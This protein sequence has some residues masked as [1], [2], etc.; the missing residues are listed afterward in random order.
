MGVTFLSSACALLDDQAVKKTAPASLIATPTS[1]YS[2]AKAKYLAAKYKENLDRIVERIVRNPKTSALQFANNI[3]SVGGIGFFTHSATKTPDERYLEVVLAT[4]ETFES[5]IDVS[6]KVQQLFSSYGTELLG[7]LASDAEIYR[8]QEMSGYGVNLAWRN[9]ASNPAGNRVTLAR[10]IVY[11]PKERVLRFLRKEINQNELLSE[12]VIFAVDEDGPLSLV[13]YRPQTLRAELRPTIREDDL[14]GSPAPAAKAP[15][16]SAVSLQGKEEQQKTE[17]GVEVAKGEGAADHSA[18]QARQQPNKADAKEVFASA[19]KSAAE[20]ARIG[21]EGQASERTTA[22]QRKESPQGASTAEAKKSSAKGAPS[23]QLK[24]EIKSEPIKSAPKAPPSIATA[25]GK[26][27]AS[28][29]NSEN[30]GA[31]IEKV[32]GKASGAEVPQKVA[33]QEKTP[34][35]AAPSAEPAKSAPRIVAAEAPQVP[36]AASHPETRS[37]S[38][39][40][41][42]AV[43]TSPPMEPVVAQK[44]DKKEA[45]PGVKPERAVVAPRQPEAFP[46]SQSDKASPTVEAKAQP[47]SGAIASTKPA[48][49]V[50]EA[51]QSTPSVRPPAKLAVEEKVA[52]APGGEVALMEPATSLKVPAKEEAKALATSSAAKADV[53]NVAAKPAAPPVAAKPQALLPKQS[54]NEA[55]GLNKL[56]ELAAETI[57]A[58]KPTAPAS[59]AEPLKAP[60]VPEPQKTA[61]APKIAPPAEAKTAE[62]AGGAVKRETHAEKSAGE[63]LALLTKPTQPPMEKT[64]ALVP[65]QRALEGFVIQLAFDDREKARHWAEAMQRR[66]YAVSLTE[67]GANGPLRVRLGNFAAREDAERQLRSLKQDGLTGIVINLPQAYRPEARSSVP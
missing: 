39:P 51:R 57:A 60:P 20:P 16:P 8:D 19:Q 54:S 10:A 42:S 22:A 1:Y 64:P 14:T 13:S 37:A 40:Y 53:P 50:E 49:R 38:Q 25:E 52:V 27:P 11:L 6:A 21:T 59:A 56:N 12:A 65:L 3:S 61:L 24:D 29:G 63:Q 15:E 55:P 58:A 45:T 17:K 33:P 62:T 9:V 31:K 32:F 48:A 35:P 36:K 46:P 30:A 47:Q 44:D 43:A 18:A 4:P 28:G 26:K 7:I 34:A 66:G 23:S 5:N 67:A 41:E 2:T